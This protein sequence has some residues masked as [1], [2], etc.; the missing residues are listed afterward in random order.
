MPHAWRTIGAL[1][2]LDP[3]IEAKTIG[4]SDACPLSGRRRRRWQAIRS[5]GRSRS[6]LL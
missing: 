3:D 6:H 2:P 1:P 4:T 5:F